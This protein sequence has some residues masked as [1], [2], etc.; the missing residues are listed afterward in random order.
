[1]LISFLAKADD[2]DKLIVLTGINEMIEK[3]YSECLAGSSQLINDELQIE[4][5]KKALGIDSNHKD[6]NEL[7]SIYKEFYFVACQYASAK[8]AKLIWRKSYKNNLSK[9]EVN[10]LVKFYSSPLGRKTVNLDLKANAEL[11]EL[12]SQRYAV[13]AYKAQ[14]TFEERIDR[15]T[16]RLN[17]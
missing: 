16:K 9:R 1:M 10:K 15:L 17:N 6:W 14:R 4:S 5:Q 8:E 7:K 11:Q 2:I 12:M 13:Q 3:S